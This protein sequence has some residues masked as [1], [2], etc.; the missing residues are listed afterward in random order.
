MTELLY[1][2]IRTIPGVIATE[3]FTYLELRKQHYN[4]GTP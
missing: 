2:Q 1:G 3:T 4:W